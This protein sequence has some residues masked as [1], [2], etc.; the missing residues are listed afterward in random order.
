[1]TIG[2]QNMSNENYDIR[3]SFDQLHTIIQTLRVVDCDL[4]EIDENIVH[5]LID[6]LKNVEPDVLNS[7]VD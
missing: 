4:H 5:E 2:E 3:L 1:M 6:M 7:F